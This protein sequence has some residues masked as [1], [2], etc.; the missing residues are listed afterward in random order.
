M[1]RMHRRGFHDRPPQIAVEHPQPAVAIKGLGHRPHHLG[2]A[3]LGGCLTPGDAAIRQHRLAGVGAQAFAT[4]SEHILVEQPGVE[5]FAHQ[6]PHTAGGVEVIDI[7]LAVGIDPREQ[8]HH[9]RERI[10]VAPVDMQA[11]CPGNRHQVNGVVGGS[12]GCQQAD[13]AVDDGARVNHPA[14][15]RVLV[16]ARGQLGNTM[17]RRDGEG[18]TQRGVRIDEGRSGQ[19]QPHHL[20]EHLV[21]VGRAIERA[22]AGAVIGL[23][24]GFEQRIATDLALGIQPADTRLL[25]IGHA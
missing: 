19:M 23:C 20:H 1:I 5:Q 11:G 24:L 6:K 17:T 8:R 7:G 21:G 16:T 15:R 2:I 12:A 4:D 14:H 18:V 9:P 22:G 3:A 25:V 13:D 10:E